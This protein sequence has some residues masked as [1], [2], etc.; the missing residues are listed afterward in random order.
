MDDLQ[1]YPDQDKVNIH[2]EYDDSKPYW[3]IL[4]FSL[5]AILTT[6]VL[7]FFFPYYDIG[8]VA[9]IIMIELSMIQLVI[10]GNRIDNENLDKAQSNLHWKRFV[11]R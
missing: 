2:E 6:I 5:F 4:T 7:W 11:R 3:K 8:T 1:T 9:V 10:Y